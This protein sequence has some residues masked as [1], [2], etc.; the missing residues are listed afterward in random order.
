[1]CGR[2]ESA[3]NRAATDERLMQAW[4]DRCD[5]KNADEVVAFERGA[6]FAARSAPRA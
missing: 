5:G 1:M 4:A 6:R 2:D 3:Y